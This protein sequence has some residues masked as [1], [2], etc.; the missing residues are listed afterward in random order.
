MGMKTKGKRTRIEDIRRA[1]LVQAA[2]RVFIERG[3]SGLTSARICEEAGMSPG[4]LAYYFKGKDQLLFDMVRYNNRVLMEEGIARMRHARSGWELFVAIVEGNFPAQ[5]FDRN[6]ANAWLSVCAAAG[7]NAQYA[8][9]QR[10]FYARL[11]SNLASAFAR[12]IDRQ[13]LDRLAL[14]IGTLIDGLW[15]RKANDDSIARETAIALVISHAEAMLDEAERAALS[16]QD[17]RPA[18]EN[19]GPTSARK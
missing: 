5:A 11:Y 15:L 10:I 17:R 9:L 14:G 19:D 12:A 16:R 13:K 8:R 2:H 1:E 4:I 18:D 7:T 3:L 6:T